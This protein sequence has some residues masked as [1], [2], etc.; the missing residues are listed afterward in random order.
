MSWL[1]LLSLA[2]YAV[3][4]NLATLT[5]FAWDK[6][7]ARTGRWRVRESTL[8]GMAAIGGTLGAVVA[9]QWL[10][11]KTRKEPFLITL[12]VIAGVQ[13]LALITMSIPKVRHA[14]TTVLDQQSRH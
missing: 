11:H 8:L 14:V 6:H 1:A 10:R 4:I 3:A 12:Y 5:A 7:C 2:I 9:Q 13:V